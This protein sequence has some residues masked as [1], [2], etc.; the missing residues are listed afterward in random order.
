MHATAVWTK[1]A[2]GGQV[3]EGILDACALAQADEFRATTHNKG[4]MNGISAVALATGNDTRALEAGAHSFA[5]QGGRYCSL[6]HYKKNEHGDLVGRLHIPIAVGTVGGMTVSHPIACVALNILGVKG[7]RELAQVMA[8]VGLAQDFAALRALV[9]AG[10]QEG[11]MRLH[12]RK[13]QL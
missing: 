3:V 7:A 12:A 13:E 2:I 9:T 6:T 1:E 10:I 8:A 11:H 4:I 5:V